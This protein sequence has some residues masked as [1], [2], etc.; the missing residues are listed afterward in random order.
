MQ[1]SLLTPLDASY[2]GH[3]DAAQRHRETKEWLKRREQELGFTDAPP[4]APDK[5]IEH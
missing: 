1:G 3:R 2:T 4:S 5:E